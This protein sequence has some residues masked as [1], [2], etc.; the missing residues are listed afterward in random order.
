M[1]KNRLLSAM[2][3]MMLTCQEASLLSTRKHVEGVS[4]RESINLYMHISAC[5]HCKNYYR[6]TQLL[7]RNI[8][9]FSRESTNG[10]SLHRLSPAEKSK[11]HKLI[12]NKIQ[13]G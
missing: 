1:A 6:Q 9:H 11:L 7:T 3:R 10:F 12:S 2:R 5:K 8:R 4:L 13:S